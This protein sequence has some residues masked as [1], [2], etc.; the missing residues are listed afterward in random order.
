MRVQNKWD[1]MCDAYVNDDWDRVA[2]AA[3]DLRQLLD[4]G[5]TPIVT[6]R[7][8]LGTFFQL[9]LADAGVNFI[10]EQ[11]FERQNARTTVQEASARRQQAGED[12][13]QSSH[14]PSS[15]WNPS[16]S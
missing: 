14:S 5:D 10:L 4:S 9:A 3:L 8:D 11:V 1:E 15:R 7:D 12:R 13:R 2:K 16:N 6:S